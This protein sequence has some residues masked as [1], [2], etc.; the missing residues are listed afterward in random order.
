MLVKRDDL[1]STRY[2]GNKVRKLEF[3]LGQARAEERDV[4]LTFGAYGSNHALATAVHARALGIEPHVVLSPQ[5]PGPF[6]AR[7]LRAHAGLGTVIHLAEGWDG[8]REAARV[9]RELRERG[10]DPLVI[11]MGGTNATGAIGYVNAAFE[12]SAQMREPGRDLTGTA[13]GVSYVPGGTLGTA[14]GLA[15]GFAAVARIDQQSVARVVAVRV[16]PGEVANEPFARTLTAETV[17]LLRSLDASFP[18][19]GYDD[20]AFELR[21]EFFEPGYG[22]PT[23]Q[24]EAAVELAAARGLKLETTYTGKA[25]SAV[26]ADVDS[27]RLTP[28]SGPVLFWDTYNSA[29]YPPAGPDEALPAPLREYVAECDRLFGNSG[30]RMGVA[31]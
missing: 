22:V 27:G 7:T 16:T 29:P 10:S 9:R 4:V 18:D 24:T 15:V 19:L 5:A 6:A 13:P 17:A 26:L 8:T 25:L 12:V 14:I 11:P 30:S 3:L 1:T 31:P 21:D 20:L 28:E 2:G 23:H